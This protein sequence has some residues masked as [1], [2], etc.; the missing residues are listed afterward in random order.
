M[1]PTHAEITDTPIENRALR[2]ASGTGELACSLTHSRSTPA[3][4]PHTAPPIPTKYRAIPIARTIHD[5]KIAC[6][7]VL[8]PAASS[9]APVI[10]AD[11]HHTQSAIEPAEVRSNTD[12]AATNSNPAPVVREIAATR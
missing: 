9:R 6:R 8:I 5:P 4:T 1:R 12:H 2:M 7:T 10:L 11:R 3:E